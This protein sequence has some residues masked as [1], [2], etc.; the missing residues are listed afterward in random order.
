MNFVFN[1]EILFF[2]YIAYPSGRTNKVFTN[3]NMTQATVSQLPAL[4]DS[5]EKQLPNSFLLQKNTTLFGVRYIVLLQKKRVGA[6][7][8][9][10][11]QSSS[12]VQEV[13]SCVSPSPDL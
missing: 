10:G 9:P 7:P 13:T 8:P 12:P 5:E 11:H 4:F 2:E 3:R 6:I 1:N